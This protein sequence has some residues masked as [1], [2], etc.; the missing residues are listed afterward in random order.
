VER[1]QVRGV[2]L[3]IFTLLTPIKTRMLLSRAFHPLYVN[4]H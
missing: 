2:M 3:L 1:A 4:Y